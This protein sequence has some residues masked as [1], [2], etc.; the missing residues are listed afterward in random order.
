M[1]GEAARSK[2]VVV[3]L[4]RIEVKDTDGNVIDL[5]AFIGTD[6][7]ATEGSDEESDD[8]SDEE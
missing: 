5:S 3:A 4:R 7:D 6:E 1:V 8:A 2:A